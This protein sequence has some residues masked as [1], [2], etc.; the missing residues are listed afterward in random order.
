[1][2]AIVE[3]E[4]I[5]HYQKLANQKFELHTNSGKIFF[6]RTVIIATGT[7]E[8]R[9]GIPGE[10]ELYGRGVSYCAVCDG[11][12]HKNQPI[13]VVGGGYSAVTE[14]LYLTKFAKTLYVAVRKD[15]FRADQNQVN[16]LLK[17][18]KNI[19]G[20]DVEVKF[21]MNT[22]VEEIFGT[23]HVTG[24]Q[25]KNTLTGKTETLKV[26]AVFPYIGSKP[27]SEFVE[28]EVKDK[29]GYLL[30]DAKMETKVEGL[31][32][33]GDVR[34]VDLRQ[35]ATATGNGALAGQM[36]VEYLEKQNR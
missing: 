35:I 30:T 23:D 24:V 11:A 29:E 32:A 34:A 15:H 25:I 22:I 4:E 6:A 8:N 13:I 16:Q 3:Y 10:D 1:L 33:A 19:L 31:Y 12:F 20:E 28:T 7:F 36:V 21:L 9:L 14:G 18:K 17:V 27:L 26:S 2:G 5:V